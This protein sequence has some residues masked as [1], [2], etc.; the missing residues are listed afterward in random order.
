MGYRKNLL[1]YW[2]RTC[3]K[4][5]IIIALHRSPSGVI[6]E[7]FIH[8]ID[9][10]EQLVQKDRYIILADLNKYP[11]RWVCL[12]QLLEVTKAYNLG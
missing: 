8:L 4:K 6:Q 2:Y 12:K 10:L 1:G 7:F 5:K 9:I 3:E 11:R